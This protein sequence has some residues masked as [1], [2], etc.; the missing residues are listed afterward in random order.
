[1]NVLVSIRQTDGESVLI[2]AKNGADIYYTV[3]RN[4]TIFVNLIGIHFKMLWKT[5]SRW[6]KGKI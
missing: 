2:E 5:V 1:M 3:C 6:L 4:D